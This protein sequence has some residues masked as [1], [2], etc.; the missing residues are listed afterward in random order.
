MSEGELK[1]QIINLKKAYPLNPSVHMSCK[2]FFYMIEDAKKEFPE[3]PLIAISEKTTVY[4]FR[5]I[6]E[7]LIYPFFDS[8]DEF[9]KK[10]FGE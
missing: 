4:E 5:L 2:D 6:F 9:K 10:W 7:K 3:R 1:K 8:Y